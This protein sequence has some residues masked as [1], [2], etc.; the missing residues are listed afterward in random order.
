MAAHN[1]TFDPHT[2]APPSKALH[3]TLWIAQ[4]ALAL[5]FGMAGIMKTPIQPRG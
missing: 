4:G 3:I 5:A 2:A 1:P